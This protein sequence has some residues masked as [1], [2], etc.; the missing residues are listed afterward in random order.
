MVWDLVAREASHIASS[1]NFA[2]SASDVEVFSMT[3]ALWFLIILLLMSSDPS[4]G[5][6]IPDALVDASLI[7]L[8]NYARLL[9]QRIMACEAVS[10]THL[11]LPTK[12]IV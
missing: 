3:A 9:S 10:Y 8:S 1:F 12:R 11:T 6:N 2:V 4:S 7:A 5:A